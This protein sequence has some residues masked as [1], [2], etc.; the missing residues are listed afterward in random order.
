MSDTV[1]I[2][3]RYRKEVTGGLDDVQ[4][5]QLAESL[6]YRELINCVG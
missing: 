3:A 1:P 2:V 5:R 6:F 4:L